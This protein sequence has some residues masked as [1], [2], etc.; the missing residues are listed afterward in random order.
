[1][2]QK[3]TLPSPKPQ[4]ELLAVWLPRELVA[5]VKIEAEAGKRPTSRQVEFFLEQ[6]LVTRQDKDAY[7]K[8]LE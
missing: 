6:V 2:R 1:L 7:I 4:K 8:S 3:T 5:R